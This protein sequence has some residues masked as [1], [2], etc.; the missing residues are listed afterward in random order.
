MQITVLPVHAKSDDPFW[1]VPSKGTSRSSGY[2]LALHVDEKEVVA[3]YPG[4]TMLVPT[5]IKV[6][7]PEGYEGQV[8]PRSSMSKK[9]IH[10]HFGTID[11][12]YRGEILVTLSNIGNETHYLRRGDRIAQLVFAPVCSAIWLP[13]KEDQTERGEGG[14]GSTGK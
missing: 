5:G 12:D 4:F 14:F 10:V 1:F 3:L 2:D 6:Q 13:W 11:S 7:I 8:R 9:G